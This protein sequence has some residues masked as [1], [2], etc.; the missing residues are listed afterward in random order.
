MKR[1]GWLAVAKRVCLVF[2]LASCGFIKA[3]LRAQTSPTPNAPD[4]GEE[5]TEIVVVGANGVR[6]EQNGSDFWVTFND[7]QRLKL[8]VTLPDDPEEIGNL[9]DEFHVSPNEEWIWAAHH[10]GSCLRGSEL[11]HR[12]GPSKIDQV[13]EFHHHAWANAVK[14][15]LFPRNFSDEGQCNMVDFDAWSVDSARML[16]TLRGG[17][18]KRA[19]KHRSIYFNT[20]T[21][22]FEL[23]DYLRKLNEKNSERVACAE[24]VDALPVEAELKRRFDSLDQQLNAKYADV[25]AK[26]DTER[27]SVLREGQRDWLKQRDAGEKFYLSL[28]S[29]AE[30]PRRRL[31]FLADVTATRIETGL[32]H[33]E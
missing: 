1:H 4:A 19:M 33:W 2:A 20:R 7:G 32:D 9:P 16:F 11:F 17:E 14:L 8:P 27:R 21:Q 5:K 22:K 23:T 10:I 26:T 31:Q 28:F 18:E 30:K 13:E 24:P 6:I 3:D 15:G 12:S 25:L 29:A